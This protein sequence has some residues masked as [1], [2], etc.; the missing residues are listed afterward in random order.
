MSDR[1]PLVYVA[2]PY[3]S[4]PAHNTHEAVKAGVCAMADGFAVIVPHLTLLADVIHPQPHETYL[5]NDLAIVERCDVVWRLPGESAGADREVFHADQN[6]I[7]VVHD[8][9]SLIGWRQLH[10]EGGQRPYEAAMARQLRSRTMLGDVLA[11]EAE[12]FIAD[13]TRLANPSRERIRAAIA[14]WRAS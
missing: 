4:N 12:K 1:I 13:A 5:T 3:S 9:G 10:W 14:G 7:V 8:Y 11:Q 6:D 2:A